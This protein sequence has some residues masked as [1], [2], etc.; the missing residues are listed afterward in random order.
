MVLLGPVLQADLAVQ[1]DLVGRAGLR[2]RL[3]EEVAL[4]GHLEAAGYRLCE[5]PILQPAAIF[6]DSGEDMR[7][8]LYL[9]SD[10]SGAD[11]CLRPEYTIPVCRLYLSQ[12]NAGLP[13]AYCYCG[14]VF[15]YRSD[16]PS[17]FVQAGLENFG[18]TDREAADAEIFGLALDAVRAVARA[19]LE[20]RL[21]D[22]GVF[23][24]LNGV[25]PTSM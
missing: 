6:F 9:T 4:A 19:D 8:K 11:Y 20:V 16:G 22:A 5:P 3:L 14:P 7:S 13:A 10:L 17:E 21:G 1:L 23:A 24:A 2:Q 15:R 18:R 12:A 25:S